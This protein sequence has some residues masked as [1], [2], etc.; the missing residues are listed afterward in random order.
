MSILNKLTKLPQVQSN[1]TKS[2]DLANDL[3]INFFNQTNG[4]FMLN[5]TKFKQIISPV[6]LL[7]SIALFNHSPL[8]AA[9]DGPVDAAVTLRPVDEALLAAAWVG[10]ADAVPA[11]LAAGADVNAR[12]NADRTALI[13]IAFDGHTA[14]VAQLLAAGADVNA[15]DNNN[16]WTAL[17][18]ATA[19]ATHNGHTA[20]VAQLLAAGAE[21]PAYLQTHAAILAQSEILRTRSPFQRALTSS[22]PNKYMSVQTITLADISEF[23]AEHSDNVDVYIGN[24][25][26]RMTLLML[27]AAKSS[28]PDT[29][30]MIRLLCAAGANANCQD[31][32]GNTALHYVFKSQWDFIRPTTIE[33]YRNW[34]L[35][36]EIV[37][38]L[39]ACGA[40]ISILN[41]TDTNILTHPEHYGWLAAELGDS[42]YM[43]ATATFLPYTS[44][45]PRLPGS[46]APRD[47]IG[48]VCPD[49]E[50]AIWYQN[51]PRPSEVVSHT[52]GAIE[53]KNT[54]AS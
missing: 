17:I 16:S 3:N 22:Y 27:V 2:R 40:D 11:A 30:E 23:I 25:A 31:H 36:R 5:I 44:G 28:S 46:F 42:V 54:E 1:F 6:L 37:V 14:V 13:W 47:I 48:L 45:Q 7:A 35:I 24:P 52:G 33:L 18:A 43:L 20:I 4:A 9:A 34:D 53:A 10:D 49:P 29:P 32:A 39:K 19:A 41:Y 21:I 51:N 50:M 12:D 26:D 15:R 38:A 8:A